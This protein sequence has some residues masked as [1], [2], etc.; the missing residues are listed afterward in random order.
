MSSKSKRVVVSLL[1]SSESEDDNE[2]KVI[3]PPIAKKRAAASKASSSAPVQQKKKAC[4][5]NCK[6]YLLY[7]EHIICTTIPYDIILRIRYGVHMMCSYHMFISYV[8]I[9]YVQVVYVQVVYIGLIG[10]TSICS[11][12]FFYQYQDECIRW[13]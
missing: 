13:E 8:H 6:Y 11:H 4:H 10:F 12:M 2:V 7:F 5:C 9:I 1:S 3:S